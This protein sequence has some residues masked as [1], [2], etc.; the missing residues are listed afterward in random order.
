[1]TY[2]GA[3]FEFVY[4]QSKVNKILEKKSKKIDEYEAVFE[5]LANLIKNQIDCSNSREFYLE[6]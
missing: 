4:L 1:M 2:G 5:K 6:V 3:L